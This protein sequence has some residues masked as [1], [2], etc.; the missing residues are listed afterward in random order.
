MLVGMNA[1]ELEDAIALPAT[2][3]E[4]LSLPG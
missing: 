3:C 4:S 1:A 2:Q